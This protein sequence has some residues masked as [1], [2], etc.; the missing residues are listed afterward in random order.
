MD[1]VKI[2]FAV[3]SNSC[4]GRP[5]IAINYKRL[6]SYRSARWGGGTFNDEIIRCI[7]QFLPE[8]KKCNKGLIFRLKVDM[9]WSYY[10][11]GA[12]PVEYFLF[13]FFEIS[14]RKRLEYLTVKQKDDI[15][16]RY[17]DFN[18]FYE[19]LENKY[20]LYNKLKQFYKREVYLLSEETDKE[21][22]EDFFQTAGE[23]FFKPLDGQC[24]EGTHIEKYN[25]KTFSEKFYSWVQ[26]GQ[27][28]IVEELI[29]QDKATSV[30]NE[31]SVNTVRVNTFRTS[32]GIEVFTCFMRVGRKG[33][34]CDNGGAGGLLIQLEDHSGLI[35]SD[36]YDENGNVYEYH[37]DS[38]VRFKGT[39]IPHWDNLIQTAISAHSI[40]LSQKFVGWDFA[41]S[42]GQ[43]VLVEGNWGAFI[44]QQLTRGKGLRKEFEQLMFS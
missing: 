1:W 39:S 14:N 21:K 43:W 26:N 8:E 28:W 31:S 15:C 38:K 32:K 35:V 3:L 41:L 11:Y 36:G 24:G 10:R 23:L 22:F 6:S 9:I 7:E 29:K 2:R 13:N 33:S 12:T 42:N 37:P 30:F 27:K 40:M 34:V 4:I 17:V 5:L 44:S 20:N 16:R 19:E 25:K 18:L